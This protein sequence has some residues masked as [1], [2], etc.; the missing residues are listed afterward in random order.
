MGQVLDDAIDLINF[1][2]FLIRGIEG[3]EASPS[4]DWKW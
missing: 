3:G 2:A 4:G 1:A